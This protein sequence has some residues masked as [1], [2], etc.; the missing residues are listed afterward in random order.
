VERS[1]SPFD[2]NLPFARLADEAERW[3]DKPILQIKGL[4]T[5]K[6]PLSR[7]KRVARRGETFPAINGLLRREGPPRETT[8][9]RLSHEWTSNRFPL[10]GSS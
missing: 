7:P 9:A 2:A 3:L 8:G 10:R 4:P 1:A 6:L 5:G